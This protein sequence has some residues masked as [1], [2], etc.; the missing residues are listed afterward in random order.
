VPIYYFEDIGLLNY[1]QTR[2]THFDTTV[3]GGHLFENF[4]FNHLVDKYSALG[5]N[6]NYWRTK[7]G[8][9][10]DFVFRVGDTLIPVEVKFKNLVKPIVGKPM[11]NFIAKYNPKKSYIVNLTFEDNIYLDG[12]EISI[13]P[14]YKFIAENFQLI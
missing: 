6:I 8:A 3:G 1:I 14:Y 5:P 4:I 12:K 9:E 7:D 10:V 11:Y 13:V 2:F